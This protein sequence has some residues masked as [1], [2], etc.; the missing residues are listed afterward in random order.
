MPSGAPSWLGAVEL[1]KG[2][3]DEG[4]VVLVLG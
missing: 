2:M 4:R 3:D 1:L